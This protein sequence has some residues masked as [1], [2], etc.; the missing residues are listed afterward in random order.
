M[1]SH[2]IDGGP[3]FGFGRSNWQSNVRKHVRVHHDYANLASWDK[4]ETSDITYMDSAGHLTDKLI[5]KGYLARNTWQGKTPMYY[6]EVK[7]TVLAND[8][9]FYMKQSQCNRVCSHSRAGPHG[10]EYRLLIESLSANLLMTDG[11]IS[12]HGGQYSYHLCNLSGLSS[13]T[14]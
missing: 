10:T 14:R 3:L 5:E 2:A 7:S 13:W 9:R 4:N 8:A 6:I 11:K 1:L 12:D